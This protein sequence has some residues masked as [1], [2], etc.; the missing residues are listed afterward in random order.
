LVSIVNI[1]AKIIFALSM[2]SWVLVFYVNIVLGWI[3][4]TSSQVLK[5]K[6]S[7]NFYDLENL[8]SDFF[9]GDKTK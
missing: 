2:G 5:F 8:K 3:S 6:K 4:P 1:V 7:T 9:E